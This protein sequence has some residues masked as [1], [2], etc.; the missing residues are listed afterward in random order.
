MS[1]APPRAQFSVN[2]TSEQPM[3]TCCS[4]KGKHVLASK[5]IPT[6]GKRE[7]VSNKKFT[8]ISN[9]IRQRS[10]IEAVETQSC[11]QRRNSRAAT[12]DIVQS[13]SPSCFP[14]TALPVYSVVGNKKSKANIPQ[15]ARNSKK[16]TESFQHVWSCS[17][18]SPLEGASTMAI[19]CT[20][21]PKMVETRCLASVLCVVFWLES[22]DQN[23][24]SVAY[25]IVHHIYAWKLTFPFFFFPNFNTRNKK[26]FHHQALVEIRILD[27][28]RRRDKDGLHNVIHMLDYFYFRSH[29]CISFEL[30]R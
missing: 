6:I 22:I 29:L 10:G 3:R 19:D 26:R 17:S 9:L 5:P 11:W 7:M 30:L 8:Q 25:Y 24:Q 14:K 16:V 18:F 2:N 12:S 1:P 20:T 27:H 28:L 21:H 15:L 23:I 4:E 13:L